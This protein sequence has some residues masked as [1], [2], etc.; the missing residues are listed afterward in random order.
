M[1]HLHVRSDVVIGPSLR[2]KIFPSIHDVILTSVLESPRLSGITSKLRQGAF[3]WAYI[4]ETIN[5]KKTM[6]TKCWCWQ[7]LLSKIQE[8][9]YIK[10]L[11]F[12]F[13]NNFIIICLTCTHLS[14]PQNA[15]IWVFYLTWLVQLHCTG[16][17]TQL[18]VLWAFMA[19]C[20]L[21]SIFCPKALAVSSFSCEG[22][23]LGRFSSG[24]WISW[25]NFDGRS[26]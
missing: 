25:L 4:K 13:S 20:M 10:I 21:I 15:Q 26:Y 9:H 5:K 7:H 2:Q 6:I 14:H 24:I 16:W 18:A 1:L 3:V 22:L 17:P 12:R 11:S 8:L 19:L 23:I